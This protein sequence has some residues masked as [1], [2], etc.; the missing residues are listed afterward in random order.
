VNGG[1]HGGEVTVKNS[2]EKGPTSGSVE[3]K[4]VGSKP[5]TKVPKKVPRSAEQAAK[6][7]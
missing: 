3:M 5:K 4:N 1:F 2:Q 6:G 7:S